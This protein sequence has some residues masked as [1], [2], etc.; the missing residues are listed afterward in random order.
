[1]LHIT[2]VAVLKESGG[3]MEQ[4]Q[5]EEIMTV[6]LVKLRKAGKTTFQR[7]WTA[8][9]SVLRKPTPSCISN[10]RN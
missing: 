5:P 10:C 7:V 4:K 3:E 9:R 8:T 2:V 6:T 1:M